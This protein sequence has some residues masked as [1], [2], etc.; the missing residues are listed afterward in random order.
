MAER[1]EQQEGAGADRLKEAERTLADARAV[2]AQTQET[3]EVLKRRRE[4]AIAHREQAEELVRRAETN[5]ASLRGER[6]GEKDADTL[7]DEELNAGIA[8]L[9]DQ[10]EIH[11]DNDR[12][13]A[14][15]RARKLR[16]EGLPLKKI[17]EAVRT[18]LLSKPGIKA[19]EP[20]TGWHH[21]K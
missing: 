11:F 12:Q 9:L 18:D 17:L 1:L 14:F 20:F 3:E 15:N 16:D 21:Q 10:I 4:E 5:L 2:L 13:H 8:T 19:E 7:S 6:L